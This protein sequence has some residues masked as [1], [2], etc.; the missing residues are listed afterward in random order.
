MKRYARRAETTIGAH[1]DEGCFNPCCVGLPGL[2]H[3]FFRAAG[4]LRTQAEFVSALQA[5][6]Q[7]EVAILT[8]VRKLS[9]RKG[10]VGIPT[11]KVT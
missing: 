11:H 3:S 10:I 9:Q 2:L 7:L 4:A 1:G 5:C 8:R 6:R